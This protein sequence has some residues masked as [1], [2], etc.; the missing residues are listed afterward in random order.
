M[1]IFIIG[2]LLSGLT[3]AKA[4]NENCRSVYQQKIKSHES[5]LNR[6]RRESKG[7]SQK[8]IYHQ[9]QRK[10]LIKV[11]Q[12]L[13]ETKGKM[14]RGAKTTE[15]SKRVRINPQTVQNVLR[16]SNYRGMLCENDNLMDF[17]E[18]ASAIR[19]RRIR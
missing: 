13:L 11:Y 1:K 15:L 12:L 16:R 6:L 9:L 8:A 17:D 3:F 19:S 10:S 18:I 5:A 14:L 4:R 7:R 2:I